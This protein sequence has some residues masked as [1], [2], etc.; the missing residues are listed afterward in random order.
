MT[1]PTKI[2]GY[3]IPPVV[4]DGRIW[5]TQRLATSFWT[6]TD[7]RHHISEQYGAWDWMCKICNAGTHALPERRED[8]VE[9][10]LEH[11]REKHP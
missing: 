2:K 9:V 1:D 6:D 10:A 8:V 11:L 5:I 7:G 4:P 3:E